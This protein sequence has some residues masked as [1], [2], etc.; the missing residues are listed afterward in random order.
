[1]EGGTVLPLTN[2]NSLILFLK[3][4]NGT[5]N[6]VG[7]ITLRSGIDYLNKLVFRIH[8]HEMNLCNLFIE[9][10][11]NQRNKNISKIIVSMSHCF[12]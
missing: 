4:M 2:L 10:P 1:M 6:T 11:Q 12:F 5:L 9:K 7:I 3:D 8:E